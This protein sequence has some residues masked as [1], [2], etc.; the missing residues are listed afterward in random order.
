[1]SPLVWGLTLGMMIG[2]IF[3]LIVFI[4]YQTAKVN[5]NFVARN[6]VGKNR[7]K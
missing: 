2:G 4:V 7:S 1:M 6:M 5:P 3:P